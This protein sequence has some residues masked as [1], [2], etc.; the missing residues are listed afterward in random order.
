MN[1]DP[2][3]VFLQTQRS[4]QEINEIAALAKLGGSR[5]IKKGI[6]NKPVVGT[7]AGK[8]GAGIL[9]N[10]RANIA[11]ASRAAALSPAAKQQMLSR[12]FDP[13]ATKDMPGRADRVAKA[14]G[15]QK[16][17]DSPIRSA[18]GTAFSGVKKGALAVNKQVQALDTPRNRA[19]AKKAVRGIGAF[20]KQGGFSSGFN[21]TYSD[22]D[23]GYKSAGGVIAPNRLIGVGSAD[24]DQTAIDNRNARDGTPIR[25]SSLKGLSPT[26]R[27][28]ALQ[29]GG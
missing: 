5:L 15:L 22:N 3:K 9:G 12:G 28:Q 20:V 27:R 17:A 4:N 16:K 21:R 10:T 2:F 6:P 24:N 8:A 14:A 19:L 18:I 11:K 26:E 29:R 25:N 7:L 13:A 1:T 23:T